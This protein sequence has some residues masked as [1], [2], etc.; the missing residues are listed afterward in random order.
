MKYL[1]LLPL[2]ML[3]ACSSHRLT[4]PERNRP[5]PKNTPAGVAFGDIA[6][7]Y[8]DD[9]AGTMVRDEHDIYHV[10]FTIGPDFDL[11]EYTDA[12]SADIEVRIVFT[13]AGGNPRAE[14]TFPLR[15]MEHQP[16]ENNTTCLD[17]TL[18]SLDSDYFGFH[19]TYTWWVRKP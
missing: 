17:R 5:D 18:R 19:C 2:L 15:A 4:L 16:G 7:R 3:F 11:G 9:I 8:M 1:Y 10:R 6:G 12:D 13:T 14:L